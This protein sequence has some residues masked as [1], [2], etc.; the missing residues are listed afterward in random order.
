MLAALYNMILKWAQHPKAAYFLAL[1]SFVESSFLPTVPPDVMLAPMSMIK[2][3]SAWNFATIATLFSVLGGILGYFLG[4]FL[5]ESL[6]QPLMIKYSYIDTYQNVLTWVDKW[7]FFAVLIAG[8]IPI[9]Y[10]M[11]TIGAGV[12][13]FNLPIFIAAAIIGRGLRFFLLS[14]LMKF[15]GNKI[16]LFCKKALTKYSKP[17]LISVILL[18]ISY[19]LFYKL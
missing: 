6:I 7:G 2:P 14:S 8:V 4:Y 12:L 3:K 5:F 13:R 9:P 1:L 19:I 15:N 17:L 10:K 16:D 11:F 18:I